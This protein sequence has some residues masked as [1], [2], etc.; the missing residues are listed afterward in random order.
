MER[1][2]TV[3]RTTAETDIAVTL[4]L[5]GQGRFQGTS[6]LGFLDHMLHLWTVHGGFD[7]ELFVQGDLKVDAHH[8]VEDLG[9]CL[10]RAWRQALGEARGI[11]RY[12]SIVLPM[13]EAL[14]LAAVDLSGRPYLAYE[15]DVP[16]C[17]L[18]DLD[19]ELIPEFLRAFV[20]EA[21]LTLH[22][23]RLAGKNGHHLIEAVFKGLARALA[24]A[25]EPDPRR[26]DVPSTK[27]RLGW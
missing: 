15:V 22:L 9:L 8:T 7:L 21:G 6:S 16:A 1:R 3:S 14:V 10:G 18:G 5:D 20:Q 25:A 4:N 17:R 26:T 13:D 24:E 19:A 2:A 23:R 11:R 27:G 12:G